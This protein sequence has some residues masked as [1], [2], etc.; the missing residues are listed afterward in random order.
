MDKVWSSVVSEFMGLS[1]QQRTAQLSTVHLSKGIL[2]LVGLH[3]S[4][5]NIPKNSFLNRPPD[6]G[7]QE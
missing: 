1:A 3:V 2:A 6:D 5:S 7:D 4:V